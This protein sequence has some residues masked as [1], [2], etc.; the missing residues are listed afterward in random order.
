[1]FITERVLQVLEIKGV[2]K[3]KFCKDIGVSAGFLDKKREITTDKY[4]NILA[5]FPD[6][7]PTWLL[8]GSGE[9][10]LSRSTETNTVNNHSG[11][12]IGALGVR[13]SGKVVNE[14]SLGAQGKSLES[15]LAE[16]EAENKS[17][18]NELV[19]LG[20]DNENLRTQVVSKE[21]IIAT[22]KELIAALKGA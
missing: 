16:L 1:M 6:V 11:G 5:Y 13:N 2:T 17:L 15:K 9:M 7:S 21:E 3:Y 8:T 14:G 12:T 10:L 22:L 4:A 19:L 18:K 20:K